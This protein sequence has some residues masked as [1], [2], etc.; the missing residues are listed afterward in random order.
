MTN[1]HDAGCLR[2]RADPLKRFLC[3]C[4][5]TDAEVAAITTNEERQP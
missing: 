5:L 2:R 1:K 3:T 4:G